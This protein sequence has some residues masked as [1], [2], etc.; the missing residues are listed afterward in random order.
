MSIFAINILIAGIWAVLAGGL[1]LANLA[2]GFLL[3]FIALWAVRPIF[4]DKGYFGRVPK[5][6]RLTVVFLGELVVSSLRVAL[7]AIRPSPRIRPGIVAVPLRARTETE[8]L[9]LSSMVTLT[10][11]SLS[12]D[13]S[14]DSRTLYVHTMFLQ[15]PEALRREITDTLETPM[16]EALR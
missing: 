7:E 9:M 13:I 3:G 8:L 11:G 14:E 12:L 5:L 16:M 6:L 4:P 15:D 1:T 2:S 10:P